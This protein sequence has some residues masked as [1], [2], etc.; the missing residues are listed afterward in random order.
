M[1]I[2]TVSNLQLDELRLIGLTTADVFLDDNCINK[3]L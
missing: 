2:R 1:R 3:V